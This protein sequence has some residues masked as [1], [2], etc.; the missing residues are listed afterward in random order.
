MTHRLCLLIL[1]LLPLP[2]VAGFHAAG[3][4]AP[5]GFS[6]K[7][8]PLDAVPQA[9][10][11]SREG[12]RWLPG[13]VIVKIEPSRFWSKSAHTFGIPSLDAFVA[14]YGTST[15]EP[16]FPGHAPPAHEGD[17]DLTKFYVMNFSSP[18]DAFTVAGELSQL[19]EVRYAEPWFVYPL[20]EVA[21]CTPNDTARHNQ[22]Y[23]NK[24]LADSAYC[25]SQGDT[26]IVIGIVDTGIQTDH[27]DLAANIWHNPGE[28]GVDGLGHDK[29]TNGID[30]DGDGYVDDWQGWDFGG[31]SFAAPVADNNPTPNTLPNGHGT[32]VAGFASA[33][34]NNTTGIAGMG[35]RC[36]LM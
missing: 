2:A 35:N 26:S 36:R 9:V 8:L 13:K 15:I 31:A 20:A 18:V 34:T 28:M 16:L 27:P 5:H 19:T 14:R 6:S 29:S 22:W 32:E 4:G 25:I 7:Q 12:S 10:L 17:V 33:V 23:L 30:D 21:T 11:K 1:L 24:T 3:K